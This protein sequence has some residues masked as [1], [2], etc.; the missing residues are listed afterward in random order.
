MK[1]LKPILTLIAG[2][3]LVGA[4]FALNIAITPEKEE[5]PATIEVNA[6]IEL[7]ETI[8]T[9][10]LNDLGEVVE[11][12]EYPYVESVDGGQFLDEK[13]EGDFEGLGAIEEVDT[14]SVD[15]FKK[16]T[17]GRCIRA[18]NVYGS[19][20]VS[21]ARAFWWSYAKR[22]VSTCGT[23]LARG[24]MAC[25]DQNAGNDFETIWGASDIIPGTWIVTGGT[26]TGH[27]C[28]ALSTPVNGYVRCLG[29]N[30]GGISCPGGGAATNIINLSLKNFIGGYIP[31]SYIPVEPEPEPEPEVLPDTSH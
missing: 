29:E 9:L 10:E 31:K 28:M 19:Q 7:P 3:L 11:G 6:S 30:Q 21:L 5:E 20:C 27:I 23:G 1:L 25:S 8:P 14:S 16:S 17:L 2:L 22:D 26:Y 12:E 24:M 13:G 15:A 18:N 4:G